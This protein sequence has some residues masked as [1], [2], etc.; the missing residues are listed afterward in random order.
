MCAVIRRMDLNCWDATEMN[1][2]FKDLD[3]SGVMYVVIITDRTVDDGLVFIRDRN[4]SVK[5]RERDFVMNLIF[6]STETFPSL[7]AAEFKL[8]S[9]FSWIINFAY[10]NLHYISTLLI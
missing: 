7:F 6:F 1:L 9:Y 3:L 8:G 4:T 5:V 10:G 2:E